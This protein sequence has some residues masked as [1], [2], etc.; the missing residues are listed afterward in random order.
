M[1]KSG[2]PESYGGFHF[3]F[4]RVLH[5]GVSR[6]RRKQNQN[7]LYKKKSIFNEKIKIYK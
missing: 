1:P 3:R 2:T 5:T 4:L 7:I 6:R